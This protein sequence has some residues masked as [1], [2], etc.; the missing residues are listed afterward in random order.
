MKTETQTRA[1][2]MEMEMA[3]RR[4]V[5]G[6]EIEEAEIIARHYLAHVHIA[7]Q[8]LGI[9]KSREGFTIRNERDENIREFLRHCVTLIKS[10][11]ALDFGIELKWETSPY[12]P[13][14]FPE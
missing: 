5:Q 14:R 11:H 6:D 4:M 2:L 1:E 3:F 13:P 9:I 10:G 7:Q 8:I 12:Q